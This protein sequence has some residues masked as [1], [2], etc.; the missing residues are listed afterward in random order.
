MQ[1][2]PTNT[3]DSGKVT[4]DIL[5]RLS[6]VDA[7]PAW[8][9]FLDRYSA[10][11][12]QTAKQFE[13][14]QDRSGE[15]FL[16]VCEQLNENGFQRLLKFNTKRKANF[17][18]WMGTVVFNLCVDWHRREFG[19]VTLLPAISALPAFDRA[20]YRLVILQGMNKETSFQMLRADF[21]DLTRELIESAVIRVY[22]LLTPR[23]R[24]QVTV[25]NRRRQ[26][27]RGSF[28][29]DPVQHLP[30]P[31]TGPEAQAQKQQDIETLQEAMVC[32]PTRQR[33]LLRLRFQ[34]GLNLK[35]IAKLTQL[36]DTN[37]AWRHVQAA[38]KALFVQVQKKNQQKREKTD[39][40]SV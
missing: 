17:K 7:G 28:S 37:R 32:L 31:G 8:V 16:Y 21:P 40:H 1:D 10:L 24:W 5:H 15:C 39:R 12:I 22:S 23:Q 6:S 26:P 29:E 27:A 19:R 3:K 18:T 14:K 20:V 35:K 4:V 36:G 2:E 11:I 34:E 38:Q 13:Y 33:L 30:D 9:E 25:Q